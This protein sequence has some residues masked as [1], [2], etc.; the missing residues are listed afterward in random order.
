[1]LTLHTNPKLANICKGPP[2]LT[3]QARSQNHHGN[4]NN[5]EGS[6]LRHGLCRHRP[7][8][9][10]GKSQIIWPLYNRWLVRPG[11][12]DRP[13]MLPEGGPVFRAFAFCTGEFSGNTSAHHDALSIVLLP[14]VYC[15]HARSSNVDYSERKPKVHATWFQ[16]RMRN[17]T[18]TPCAGQ[19]GRRRTRS[20]RG[21]VLT[22]RWMAFAATVLDDATT[23]NTASGKDMPRCAYI[24]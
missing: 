8:I 13:L 20:L 19:P 5:H 4:K 10:W 22:A 6:G 1:M 2:W 3:P 12:L 15:I 18:G 9:C 21:P 16:C 24:N 7:C 14:W 23:I 11:R 17:S